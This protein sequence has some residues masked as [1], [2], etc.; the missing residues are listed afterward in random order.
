VL[1]TFAQEPPFNDARVAF[2]IATLIDAHFR[3]DGARV[4]YA[5]PEGGRMLAFVD[6]P[7]APRDQVPLLLTAAGFPGGLEGL[8]VVGRC[9][10]FSAPDDVR[11]SEAAVQ[12]ARWFAVSLKELG[13]AIDQCVQASAN[14]SEDVQLLV[15]REG[16]P[17]PVIPNRQQ[18]TLLALP[19]MIPGPT[20]VAPPIS[21]DAGLLV[22][23][24]PARA[25]TA[26][27]GLALAVGAVF[28]L[29]FD[30]RRCLP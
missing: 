17:I 28:M 18:A 30:R 1:W 13:I 20:N 27:G 11:S 4:F 10:A 21:G 6:R 5:Q 12:V 23:E 22:S 15:W 7:P 26:I 9:R 19:G 24:R 25:S 29:A 2:A 8:N 16:E 14:L 3:A